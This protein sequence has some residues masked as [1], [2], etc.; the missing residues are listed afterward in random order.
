MLIKSVC[1]A[2]SIW[3]TVI[4]KKSEFSVKQAWQILFLVKLGVKRVPPN[5]SSIGFP[6]IFRKPFPYKTYIKLTPLVVRQ[7]IHLCNTSFKTYFFLSI[8]KYWLVTF[9][10]PL[11]R[12]FFLYG[13]YNQ[14]SIFGNQSLHRHLHI[15]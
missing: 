6:N 10:Q 7:G 1:T 11:S 5:T 8:S 4:L 2:A 9:C 3:E 15:F 13:F 14:S 12:M